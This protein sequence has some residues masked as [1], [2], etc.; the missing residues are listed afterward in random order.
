VASKRRQRFGADG[1]ANGE[2]ARQRR[3]SRRFGRLKHEIFELNFDKPLQESTFSP[4][5][6][7]DSLRIWLLAL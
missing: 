2:Y 7:L 4:T 3:Y 5:S 6:R 1:R